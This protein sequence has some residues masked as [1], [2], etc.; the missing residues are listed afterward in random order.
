MRFFLAVEINSCILLASIHV[1]AVVE[2]DHAIGFV[3][4]LEIFEVEFLVVELWL[5]A[6]DL[7]SVF[8]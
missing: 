1:H 5:G 2:M 3:D 6:E 8:E 7:A 4:G